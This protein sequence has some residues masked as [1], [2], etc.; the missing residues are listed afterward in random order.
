MDGYVY[1]VEQAAVRACLGEEVLADDMIGPLFED[2]PVLRLPGYPFPFRDGEHVAFLI[3]DG[4]RAVALPAEAVHN[5]GEPAGPCPLRLREE[6]ERLPQSQ[7]RYASE[8]GVEWEV[9]D[10]EGNYDHEPDDVE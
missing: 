3:E 8:S 10:H 2:G 4:E 5:T 9:E 1:L 7:G 6:I